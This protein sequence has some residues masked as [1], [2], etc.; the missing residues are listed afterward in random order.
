MPPGR[1]RGARPSPTATAASAAV[2]APCTQALG[3]PDRGWWWCRAPP[4][5]SV[6]PARAA[7][8]ETGY[9]APVH[10]HPS[11]SHGGP[12]RPIGRA[13]PSTAPVACDTGPPPA[14]DTPDVGVRPA[15]TLW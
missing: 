10:H 4:G 9:G 8:R 3:L 13:G 11:P 15:P 14:H 2:R 7:P 12:A 5:H 6:R 1:E